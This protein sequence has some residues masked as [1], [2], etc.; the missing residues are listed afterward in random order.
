MN[1]PEDARLD[2]ILRALADPTRRTLLASIR[3]RPGLTTAELAESTRGMTRW[4]VMKHLQ[5]LADAALIQSLPEGR[6]R[7]HYHEPQGLDPLTRWLA[8]QRSER[9]G[10]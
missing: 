6:N 9:E 1:S 5:A 10:R 2:A 4:G 8:A 3:A 7:R